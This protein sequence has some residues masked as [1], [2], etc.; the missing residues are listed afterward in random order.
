MD[1][2]DDII[3]GGTTISTPDSINNTDILLKYK[4]R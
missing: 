2:K 4:R 1:N 3:T